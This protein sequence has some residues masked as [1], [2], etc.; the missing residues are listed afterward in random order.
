MNITD[1]GWAKYAKITDR[2]R[3]LEWRA[4]R[5]Q[6]DLR[7]REQIV[8][9]WIFELIEEYPEL[10]NNT[11]WRAVR[12]HFAGGGLT[13]PESVRDGRGWETVHFVSELQDYLNF[14]IRR[15]EI[16]D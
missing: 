15:K 12:T 7:V 3:P 5:T 9:K 16:E 1:K 13:I 8:Q 11:I 2:K 10:D 6:A 4:P 14:M